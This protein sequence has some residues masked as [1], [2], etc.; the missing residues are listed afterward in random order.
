MRFRDWRPRAATPIF[1]RM[2]DESTN[3]RA[4]LAADLCRV[5]LA[6]TLLAL[7]AAFTP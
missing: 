7:L 2:R 1:R 5:T 3:A 6:L 4:G